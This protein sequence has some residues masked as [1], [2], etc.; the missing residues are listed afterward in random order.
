MLL[1]AAMDVR[2]T[3]VYPSEPAPR[4]RSRPSPAQIVL[5]VAL[6]ASLVVVVYGSFVD[7]SAAQVPILGS[8][9]AVMGLTLL[10]FAGMGALASVRAGREGEG[11]RAFGAALIGGICALAAAGALGAALVLVL[12][13]GSAGRAT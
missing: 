4:P 9:L 5:L 11:G 7:K 12:L 8:G 2:H 3:T 10:A 13:W 6:F 1:S